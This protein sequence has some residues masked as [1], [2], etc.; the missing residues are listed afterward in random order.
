VQQKEI[1]R[2]SLIPGGATIQDKLLLLTTCPFLFSLKALLVL[3]SKVSISF[4]WVVR[5]LFVQ[6]QLTGSGSKGVFLQLPDKGTAPTQK[7]CLRSLH[8]I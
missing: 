4:G 5:G 6:K 7:I 8:L 1:Q 3:Q 2:R